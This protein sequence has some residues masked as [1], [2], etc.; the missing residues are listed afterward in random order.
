MAQIRGGLSPLGGLVTSLNLWPF[1]KVT[2][3]DPY[4]WLWGWHFEAGTCNMR[5]AERL[6]LR[7]P[8]IWLRL[9]VVGW[10][11][12]A[13]D[14][15]ELPTTTSSC[16]ILLEVS[17]F[18]SFVNLSHLQQLLGVE[19]HLPVTAEA[20]LILTKYSSIW[21]EKK[22]K[23]EMKRNQKWKKWKM[24]NKWRIRLPKVNHKIQNSKPYKKE[25][26]TNK[27]KMK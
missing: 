3:L 4:L 16:L 27:A 9:G 18:L 21:N 15:N 26:C 6:A 5:D 13:C 8:W 14:E 7:G 17:T 11:S 2:S 19:K 23:I 12:W 22:S 20:I 10:L 25:N 1:V 24:K